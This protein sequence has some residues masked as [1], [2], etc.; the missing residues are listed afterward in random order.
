VSTVH[1]WPGRIRADVDTDALDW[2]AGLLAPVVRLVV[3]AALEAELATH[4]ADRSQVRPAGV[5]RRNARNGTRSKT[6][7][8]AFGPVTIDAPRDRWGTFDP[9]VVGKWQRRVV[10]VDQLT[11]PLA[12]HGAD[13][14]EGAALLGRVYG[15]PD[16]GPDG[17]ALAA[18]VAAE[19]QQRAHRW[20]QRALPGQ[21]RALLVDR[22]VVRS[23][24]GRVASTPVRTVVAE[25]PNGW[26]QLVSLRV[27]PELEC[28]TG[29]HDCL[30]DLAARGLAEVGTVVAAPVPGLEDVVAR[31]WP[32]AL[33][34]DRDRPGARWDEAVP[35]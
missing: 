26:R 21:A 12:A 20:H 27:A 19:V 29:W 31:V 24:D 4:L 6:V 25:H 18:R 8:T 16:R 32:S 33:R 9:V 10:G 14:R 17:A 13:P 2:R 7:R 30:V 1:A 23:K 5:L 15:R 34:V 3:E 28:L 11:V 35:A 22:A